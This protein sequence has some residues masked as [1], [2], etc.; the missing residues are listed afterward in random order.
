LRVDYP[1][2]TAAGAEVL[3]I[4]PQPLA[5][6]ARYAARADLPFPLLADPRRAVYRRY[7][8]GRAVWSFGQRPG[9]YVI[10]RAG[11][12]QY[13]VLGAQMWELPANDDVLAVLSALEGLDRAPEPA[14]DAGPTDVA[15][16][17][18]ADAER[19]PRGEADEGC[20]ACAPASDWQL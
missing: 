15:T 19:R 12:V 2:F 14:R 6:V 11:V 16:S 17:I 8:V 18:A 13:A 9:L 5:D 10:D 1:R 20:L 3:A 4:A 7:D